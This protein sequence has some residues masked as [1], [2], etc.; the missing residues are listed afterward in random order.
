MSDHDTTAP[1]ADTA[2]ASHDAGH[3]DEH[4]HAADTLGPIDWRM[5]GVG[6]LGGIAALIVVAGFV[7]ST[8]FVFFDQ[9]A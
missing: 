1:H 8:G 2:D 7:V 6:V 9:L 3:H 4:G 5:W